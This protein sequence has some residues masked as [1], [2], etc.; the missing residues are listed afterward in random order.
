MQAVRL[1]DMCVM[2]LS[3]VQMAVKQQYHVQCELTVV[4]W[5]DIQLGTMMAPSVRPVPARFSI[6]NTQCVDELST[7]RPEMLTTPH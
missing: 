2:V 1:M 3:S 7:Y 4:V 6:S 5:K